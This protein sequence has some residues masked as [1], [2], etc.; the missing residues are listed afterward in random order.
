MD[1]RPPFE[2]IERST[3]SSMVRDDILGRISS[4]ELQPGT[5]LPAERTLAE[6]FDVARTSVREAIQALIAIGAVE[7]RGNRSYIS[8]RVVGAELP[9]PDGRLKTVLAL[10]EA[11][12][13]MELSLF[14]LAASRATARA[15][16]EV[17]EL[18]RTPIPASLE[19]FVVADRRFH[20][21][22]ARTCGNQVLVEMYGRLLDAVESSDPSAA[23]LFGIPMGDTI[24]E[25]DATDMMMRL[26]NEHL[27]IARAFA[28]GDTDR[29]LDAL[30]N[31]LG[32]VEGLTTHLRHRARGSRGSKGDISA[33]TRTVGM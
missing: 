12:R 18:A 28:E 17:L 31:H 2:P 15:R 33:R 7:R 6:Q 20:A 1:R 24:S 10:I 3:L 5:R 29:L 4:G 32:P 11:K 19:E 23:L 16:T 26:A 14:A 22:I 27:H 8:E 25:S 9:D 30:E 21:A 13:V